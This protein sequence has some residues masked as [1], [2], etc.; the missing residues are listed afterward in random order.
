MGDGGKFKQKA[1]FS[2]K[3]DEH[4]LECK[5]SNSKTEFTYCM[6]PGGM[7]EGGQCGAI[8][9][10]G[11]TNF[12]DD[13]WNANF[14]LTTGGFEVGP[15]KP[16]TSITCDTNNAG[17][18]SVTYSQNLAMYNMHAGWRVAADKS[19][20]LTEAHA[21][22]AMKCDGQV[23]YARA[24]ILNKFFGVGGTMN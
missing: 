3:M 16:W 9:V 11:D 14:K 2:T 7:N 4:N 12:K 24:D 23:Y 10:G 5:V 20:K 1:E 6:T 18:H 8:E 19:A 22:A 15:M 13:A 17:E 21:S